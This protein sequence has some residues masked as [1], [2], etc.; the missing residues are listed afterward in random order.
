MKLLRLIGVVVALVV[1]LAIALPGSA[2]P[3]ALRDG[4]VSLAEM[5]Q[6]AQ[7]YERCVEA[8]GLDVEAHFDTEQ[9]VFGYR[10]HS[11]NGP[12]EAILES[13]AG[14]RCHSTHLTPVEFAWTDQHIAKPGSAFLRSMAECVGQAGTSLEALDRAYLRAPALYAACFDRLY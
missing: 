6:A 7:N 4:K 13:D 11:D 10:M 9:V 3:G 5:S 2:G 12:V 14:R 1:V 8:L